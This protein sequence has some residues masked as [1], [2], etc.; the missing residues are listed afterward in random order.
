MRVQFNVPLTLLSGFTNMRLQL[1]KHWFLYFGCLEETWFSLYLR[2]R[3]LLYSICYNRYV[4]WRLLPAFNDMYYLRTGVARLTI[5]LIVITI[6]G[7]LLTIT[8][9]MWR[10]SSTRAVAY[11]GVSAKQVRNQHVLRFRSTHFLSFSMVI[12]LLRFVCLIFFPY[13]DTNV[14]N[15]ETISCFEVSPRR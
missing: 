14:A 13:L 9:C 6:Y 10:Y 3:F 11:T 15:A 1:C 12:C 8:W 4:M 7:L 2:L 5:T